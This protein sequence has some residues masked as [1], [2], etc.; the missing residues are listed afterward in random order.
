MTDR[1]YIAEMRA[2]I[3][4]EA[5]GEYVSG[6]VAAEVVGKLRANDP[7]LLAGWLDIQAV[8]LL[9]QAINNRDRSRRTAARIAAPRSVFASAAAAHEG[10]DP[11][12]LRGLL[13]THYV[14]N[15]EDLRKPLASMTANDLRYVAGRYHERAEDALMEEAFFMALSKKVG[16]GTVGEHFTE[17]QVWEMRKSLRR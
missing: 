2:L 4:K 1:D 9:H 12:P 10:G 5:A 17:E 13:D 8:S 16:K 11:A 7:D 14:V 15:P 3:D 6:L